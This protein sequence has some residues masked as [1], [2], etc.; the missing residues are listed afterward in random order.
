[1]I[2]V[3][4]VLEIGDLEIVRHDD[5]AS[6]FVGPRDVD[7]WMGT[8]SKSFGSCGGYIAGRKALVE[9]LKY[10]ALAGAACTLP[11][12]LLRAMEGDIILLGT[13]ATEADSN[14][15]NIQC[16]SVPGAFHVFNLLRV[17]PATS[18]KKG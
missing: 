17:E 16:N 1:M 14:V 7:I 13:V 2:E 8:L 15:A 9:Y 12:S 5:F 11:G 4:L 18:K 10:T 3:S 6:N